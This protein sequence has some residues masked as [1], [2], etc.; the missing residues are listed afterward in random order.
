MS[1]IIEEYNKKFG[2]KVSSLEKSIGEYKDSIFNP[3]VKKLK[4][5]N[6]IRVYPLIAIGTHHIT[7]D[8][9]HFEYASK[10]CI[11]TLSDKGYKIEVPSHGYKYKDIEGTVLSKLFKEIENPIEVPRI[12]VN[13][14]QTPDGTVIRSNHVHDYV[15]HIDKNGETYMVDGGNEYLKRSVNK[16]PAKDLSL[17][18]TDKFETIRQRLV[19]GNRGKD[20]RSPLT[21]KILKDM[22]NDHISN[23]L[24]FVKPKESYKSL[25]EKE[26]EYR[27]QNKINIKD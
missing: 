19:W 1:N 6:A 27:K 7:K 18:H 20:G 13:A 21:Y 10:L 3:I 17:Y 23:I 26:L 11:L 22:S 16:I 8:K 5:L 12:V 2:K 15:E 9:I 25:F 4:K 24:T 14:M